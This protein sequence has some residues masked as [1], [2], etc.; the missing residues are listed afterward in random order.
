MPRRNPAHR[1]VEGLRDAHVS[2]RPL[3]LPET[4]PRGVKRDGLRYEQHF[5]KALATWALQY[6][7][8]HC[9]AGMWFMY[10]DVSG[11]GYCQ[12]D[13]YLETPD[14]VFI[15]ECKLTDTRQAVSQLNKL[16]RPVLQAALKKPTYGIVVTR[17][18]TPES[19]RVDVVDTIA[20]ALL[21]ARGFGGLPILHW[22]ER[23]PL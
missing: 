21:N 1:I 22:R 6:P 19:S 15:F 12:P 23:S 5:A 17:H 20:A 7:R 13:V 8:W 4:R 9:I 3:G 18:L 11:K 16:Y 2:G 14:H 10:S